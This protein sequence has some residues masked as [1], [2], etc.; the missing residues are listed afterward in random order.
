MPSTASRKSAVR[1]PFH[2]VKLKEISE[3]HP[4]MQ[5]I[6]ELIEK[7]FPDFGWPAGCDTPQQRA[8]VVAEILPLDSRSE[9]LTEN[10]EWC[11]RCATGYYPQD[12]NPFA[13][14]ASPR[15]H[16]HREIVELTPYATVEP[17]V[18]VAIKTALGKI[19][20]RIEGDEKSVVIPKTEEY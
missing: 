11:L 4:G 1:E 12:R 6:L 16:T 7:R 2:S 10:Q 15:P 18:S 20:K 17:T 14:E 3:M 19:R 13:G 5:R 8:A 9:T